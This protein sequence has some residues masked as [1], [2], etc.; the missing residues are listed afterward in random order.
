MR[1]YLKNKK[2]LRECAIWNMLQSSA[3]KKHRSYHTPG[4]KVAKWDITEL[5][6]SDNLSAPR[7]CIAQ[8]ET[9]IAHILGAKKSFILTDGSTA[10]VLAML[11]ASKKLGVK[12]LLAVPHLHKCV[13]NG[14]EAL[15]ITLLLTEQEKVESLIAQVDALLI[16]SP[17]YFGR[18][19]PMKK[20][21]ELCDAHGK[22]LLI[23]GAHGGHLHFSRYSYAGLFADFWVDGVH[24]SLPAFTQ[25]A[26]VSAKTEKGAEV[27]AK[28]V[29]CFRTTS[30]SYPI[31]ASVEY[32]VKYPQNEHLPSAVHNF[33]RKH[34][35]V[36]VYDWT[37]IITKFG[38]NAFEAEKAF[39]AKGIY[40]EFCDGE[41][42]VF[43]LSPAT[44]RRDFALLRRAI[45]RMFKK[46]PYVEKPVQPNP[47]PVILQVDGETEW[48]LIADCEG[49]VCAQECGLFPPCTPLIL[50]GERIEKRHIQLMQC[51][52]NVFGVVDGKIL[53]FKEKEEV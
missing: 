16:T 33:Y 50:K 42:I 37:K 31:M 43:Y 2:V 26:V 27:L 52:N 25:G 34:D 21:R 30:P 9:D 39:E 51:A 45:V 36:K 15:G 6:Y 53:V 41:H 11:Y 17:D 19:A 22:L 1:K 5:S 23:D 38:A 4:H 8:A 20:F 46:F 7:G 29:D 47:A 14:C 24:K 28:G 12:K 35:R 3:K 32:A 49:R 44:S 18:E 40:P 13:Y 10:G 48:V